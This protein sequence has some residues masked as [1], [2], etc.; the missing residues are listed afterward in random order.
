MNDLLGVITPHLLRLGKSILFY[1]HHHTLPL[2]KYTYILFSIAIFFKSV[3]HE[4]IDNKKSDKCFYNSTKTKIQH[5]Q[6][7]NN[8]PYRE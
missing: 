5:I 6:Q 4:K 1:H 7:F 3:W 8:H 2:T